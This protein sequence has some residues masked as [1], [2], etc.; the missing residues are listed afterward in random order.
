[1]RGLKTIILSTKCMEEAEFICDRIVVLDHG[2]VKCYGVP[3]FLQSLFP[4]E[5]ILSVTVANPGRINSVTDAVRKLVKPV[6]FR[7]QNEQILE[8]KLSSA[9]SASFADLFENLEMR[10]REGEVLS[11]H[12]S[13]SKLGDKLLRQ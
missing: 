9:E 8:F 4:L 10:Q 6:S 2:Q 12:V 13:V 11:Y 5:F 3:K 7:N 1:M